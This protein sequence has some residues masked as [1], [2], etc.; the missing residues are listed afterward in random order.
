MELIL[1][2]LAVVL[3]YLI[4]D[5]YIRF[6]DLKRSLR[7]LLFF[8]NVLNKALDEK[9]YVS[10]DEMREFGQRALGSLPEAENKKTKKDL[11][12]SGIDFS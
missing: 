9:G 11:Q 6:W 8:N 2:I 5:M 4:G 10:R 12:K 1:I 7:T 3:V